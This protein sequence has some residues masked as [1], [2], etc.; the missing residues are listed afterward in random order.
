MLA[1]LHCPAPPEPLPAEPIPIRVPSEPDECARGYIL[2]VAG[3]N[4]CSGKEMARWLGLPGLEQE[5]SADPGPA[6]A[7]LGIS[8]EALARMGFEDGEAG[9][10]LGHRMPLNRLHRTTRFICPDCLAAAP[11]QRRI[12]SLRQLDVCPRHERALMSA[13]PECEAALRWGGQSTIENCHCGAELAVPG[14]TP[15]VD[16]SIGA[17]VVYLHCGLTAPG[18][19]LPPAF[20]ALPLAALLDLLVFLGRMDLVIAQGNPDGLQP[21]EM[22]TDRRVLSAGARIGLGWPDA[23]DDL[24]D[25][26]R[27]ARP[28]MSGVTKEYGYLH[29]FIMRSG[30]APYSQ[31]LQSAYADHL[32]RRGDV[33]GRVWPHALPRP[34]EQPGT[35]TLREVQAAL[36]LGSNSFNALRRQ[37]LWTAIKPVGPTRSGARN[38]GY[39]YARSDIEALKEKLS[40]LVS[41]GVADI[42]L[43]MGRGKT[44]QLAEADLVTVYQWHR[45]H[46]NSE[47]RS[48]DLEEIEGIFD[49]IRNLCVVSAPARPLAFRTLKSMATARRV[50]SFVDLIRC[51]LSGQLRGYLADP[52]V[53][54]LG[55]LVF[56][57]AHAEAAMDRMSSPAR[58]GEMVLGDV[59]RC[60]GIP[61]KAVHQLVG[62]G[63]LPRPRRVCA[64]IF[65]ADAIRAFRKDFT[66]DTELARQRRTRP[67]EIRRRLAAAGIRPVTTI[68]S[69]RGAAVAV[70]RKTEVKF[71]A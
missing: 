45:H 34:A 67:D 16:D 39:N 71:R 8:P 26:V 11:Y 14:V 17:R 21:R 53:P 69:K 52:S 40:R 64:Y 1:P 42:M 54:R 38:N 35:M 32:A 20:A 29:R 44:A 28:G 27:A 68:E 5:L 46:R 13:C 41:P 48:V 62:E 9:W 43:G 58:T 23:F 47:Q 19:G 10:V 60:L 57:Q 63:L 56:E 50:V 22:L 70:Y 61:A 2:R 15:A 31:L 59:V 12:W 7:L 51:L 36:G 4:W 25:R 37:P 33:L 24:A 6:A 3:R 49:R 30:P 55:G 66:Y 18:D 65:G